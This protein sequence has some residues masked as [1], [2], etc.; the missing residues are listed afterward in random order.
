MLVR[1]S[2]SLVNDAWGKDLWGLAD[3]FPD[4]LAASLV[5][6]QQPFMYS[7]S[8]V[9]IVLRPSSIQGLILCAYPRDG[10][11]MNK[12]AHGCYGCGVTKPNAKAGDDDL[13]KGCYLG[14][15][16][17]LMLLEAHDLST[18]WQSFFHGNECLWG[19]PTANDRGSCQ[20][21][22]IV[23]DGSR[24]GNALPDAVEAIFY[25]TN[26]PVD[27]EE[28]NKERAIGVHASFLRRYGLSNEDVP[29]L[30]F[31]VAASR[32]GSATAPKPWSEHYPIAHWAQPRRVTF[33]AL[34]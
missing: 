17:R 2:D 5:N 31:D 12:E 16:I 33:S 8:A 18:R 3:N 34:A 9:G 20:Y 7:T 23:V 14:G 1:Q 13:P 29:L 28:G 24:Y 30:K 32:D 11:S 26:G 4:R 10:N 27:H 15:Q 21:N 22:E 25:P 19:E 6:A